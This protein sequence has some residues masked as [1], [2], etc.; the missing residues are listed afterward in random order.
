MNTKDPSGKLAR[1][2]LE[3]SEYDMEVVFRRGTENEAPDALSRMFEDT[4]LAHQEFGALDDDVSDDW[5][6]EKCQVLMDDPTAIEGY[7]YE[8]GKLYRR[9]Y[10]PFQAIVEDDQQ[11]RLVVH[12]ND[13]PIALKQV[14]DHPQAGHLDMDKTYAR[15]RTRFYGPG[16]HRDVGEYDR[17]CPVC[18]E[19][20][21]IQHKPAGEMAPRAPMRPWEVV[22]A[23]TMSFTRSKSGFMYLLVFEDSYTRWIECVPV[24]TANGKTVARA[25]AQTIINRWGAPRVF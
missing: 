6:D 22:A 2:A 12:Q 14:H 20:K 18:L 23:D 1:W 5:Y 24:R 7:K 13:R 15:A 11:W 17:R 19:S 9:H 3:L 16:M 4:E 25:F 10:D 8:A 21:P